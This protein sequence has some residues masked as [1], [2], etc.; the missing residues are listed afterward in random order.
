MSAS[1]AL[2]YT[3]CIFIH[4]EVVNHSGVESVLREAVKQVHPIGNPRRIIKL[5]SQKCARCRLILRRTVDV[6]YGQH[7]VARVNPAPPYY[8]MM[9]DI[10]Y[11]FPGKPHLTAVPRIR[12][13]ALI[14]V[15]I[16]TG[17]TS[18][19]ALE[20]IQT[21]SVVQALERH[22]SRYGAPHTIYVDS[23]T[24]LVNL[25]VVEFNLRDLESS[26]LER[27]NIQVKTS[28]PYEPGES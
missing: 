12:L 19:M 18:I 9:I 20:S 6:D 13:Y 14:C 10:A 16:L 3:L 28:A 8:H 1:S 23:G 2:F 17:A 25:K 15:C 5:I 11:G 7:P 26:L 21:Q 22:S 27:L 24:Q 4:H